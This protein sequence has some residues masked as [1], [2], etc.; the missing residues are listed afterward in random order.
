[1]PG[2]SEPQDAASIATFKANPVTSAGRRERVR[3]TGAGQEA[4]LHQAA[5]R[6]VDAP[7]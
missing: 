2:S 4:R 6:G 7:T 1:M 3:T 5:G